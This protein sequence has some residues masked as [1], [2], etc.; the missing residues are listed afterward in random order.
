[1]YVW[2]ND[3]ILI[4]EKIFF[5]AVEDFIWE[6]IKHYTFNKTQI[7][8]LSVNTYLLMDG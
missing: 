6:Y 7:L 1:M 2:G 8:L 5:L 4:E 3:R